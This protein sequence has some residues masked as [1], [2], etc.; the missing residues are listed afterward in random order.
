MAPEERLPDD[1]VAAAKALSASAQHLDFFRLVSFIERLT[2]AAARVGGMGP[3]SEEMIRFRHDPSLTFASGDVASVALRQVPARAE[4]SWLRRPLLE[5]MTRFL[6]LTGAVSPL[7][8]Y[9]SEEVAQEDEDEAYRRE[10]LDLFHH[11]LLS[12]LYRIESKYRVT[13]ESNRE[14]T[15]Q[16]AKRLLALAGFDTYEQPWQGRLPVWRLLRIAPLLATRSRTADRLET[17]LEDVLGEDLE[18]AR[19][20]VHQF[21]GRWV[22]IDA[23]VRLGRAYHQLGRNMLLGGKAYDRTGKVRVHIGALPPSAFRR[24]LPGGDLLPVVK[25]VVK[26]FKRDPLEY[27]LELELT[28]SL[29]QTFQLSSQP[30]AQLGRDTWLGMGRQMRRYVPLD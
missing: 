22:D 13:P 26:L 24:L 25:E 7:P 19:V 8:L 4:E 16:W 21:I 29:N 6:G 27:E 17:A 5:V 18:G 23:R 2:Y 10:F 15:D 28:E 14:C 1:L 12:L 30:T 9:M 20:T 3:V 11:R